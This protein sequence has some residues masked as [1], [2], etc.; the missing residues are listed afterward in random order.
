MIPIERR[1]KNRDG[2]AKQE[3]KKRK[4][5]ERDGAVEQERKKKK[6]EE[7]GDGAVKWGGRR[8]STVAAQTSMGADLHPPLNRHHPLL[9]GK[10]IR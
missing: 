3:R 6:E 8:R 5:E 7:N 10:L 2:A 4:M 9:S 1:M